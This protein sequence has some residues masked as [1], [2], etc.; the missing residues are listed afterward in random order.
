MFRLWRLAQA[1]APLLLGMAQAID[2]FPV[3]EVRFSP[4]SSRVMALQVGMQD[5]TGFGTAILDILETRSGRTLYRRV[6][7]LENAPL[8]PE[9]KR[10]AA[11]REQLLKRAAPT[12]RAYGLT[13]GVLSRPRYQRQS[14]AVGAG[15][16]R[17][18]AVRLW[19]GPVPITLSAFARPK[20][21][22]PDR[23][24]LFG[25][26]PVGVQL[27]V[28]N[29]TMYRAAPTAD[30]LGC[31]TSYTLDRV[32]VRG[33]RILVTLRASRIGFEGMD[34]VAVFAAAELK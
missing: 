23:E 19:S 34:S 21:D 10:E 15:K 8:Q 31:A 20:T 27:Q 11:A 12:L 33:N 17:R 14:Q 3:T 22:C 4:D 13:P 28:R 30:F 25:K 16:S 6:E 2:H 32:D 24:W 29:Q 18:Q 7:R 9:A 5:G 26:R 1:L